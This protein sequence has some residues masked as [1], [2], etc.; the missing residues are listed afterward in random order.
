MNGRLIKLVAAAALGSAALFG[1]TVTMSFGNSSAFPTGAIGP[2]LATVNGMNEF[3]Y[4]DDDTHTVYT[5]ETWTATATSLSSLIALGNANI[6]SGSTVT[7]RGISN[8]AT[9]YEQVAWLVNQF[10]SHPSDA[11]GLQ[12]A[13][14]DLFLLKSGTG[15]ISDPSTDAYWIQQSAANYSTLTTAQIASFT[16]L[17]PLAG[18]QMP[19]SAGL[20]QEFFTMAPEPASY[21]L[22][23]IG[24]VLLSLGSF[25]RKGRNTN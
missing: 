21:A 20:P 14:W 18:T 12:N 7:W 17:T 5:N 10:G 16:I 1:S 9:V 22:F 24:I 19:V 8:A 13:I 4:C 15:S 3:V 25:R 2:Y 11:S 6:A 23:G